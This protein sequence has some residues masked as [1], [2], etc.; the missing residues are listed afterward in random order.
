M[1]KVIKKIRKNDKKYRKTSEKLRKKVI[2][3]V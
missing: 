1:V 3:K 2:E